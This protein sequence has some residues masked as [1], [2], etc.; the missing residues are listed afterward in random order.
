MQMPRS[1]AINEY[2]TETSKTAIYPPDK[3][4]EYLSLG[5]TSEAGEVAGKVKKIIR[6]HSGVIDNNA[7]HAIAQE[8][9]DVLW[10]VAQIA[11][12]LNIKLADIAAM[13]I[14]KLL[15]RQKND[16]IQGNGDNR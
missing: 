12:V 10:Y 16:T 1:N 9:G 5:L 2:Q 13:N 15:D 6:D 3:A 11:S 8:L 4:I 14:S 7:G